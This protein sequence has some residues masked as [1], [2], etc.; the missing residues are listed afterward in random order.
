[1]INHEN[2]SKL[3]EEM[4]DVPLEK[5]NADGSKE[6]IANIPYV[7]VIEYIQGVSIWQLIVDPME[8]NL[9]QYIYS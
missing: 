8:E 2:V 1:M 4:S 3:V 9:A 7:A 5:I 6:L